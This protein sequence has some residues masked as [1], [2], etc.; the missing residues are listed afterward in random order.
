MTDLHAR[1]APARICADTARVVLI[2]AP[3]PLRSAVAREL[4]A[5]AA[6]LACLERPTHL[7][8]ALPAVAA[9]SETGPGGATVV[10]V[11]VP[12]LPGLASRLRHRYRSQALAADFERAVTA[13]RNHGIARVIVLS[14]AFRYDDDRGLAL[15]PGSPTLTSAEAAPAAAAEEAARLFTRLGV[16]SVVLRLGWTCGREEGIARRVLSAAAR[17]WRLIDADPAAWVPMIAETDAA[18][19]VRP[20]L[21]IPPGTYDLTDGCP[22][23]QG[24]LNARLERACGRALHSLGDPGWGHEG[25]LFGC[26]R[27]ITG[28]AFGALTGW[29]P[30]VTSAADSLAGMLSARPAP[31]EYSRA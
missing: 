14:T 29:R 22:V 24:M 9:D 20:A 1:Q 6:L 13:A 19:A 11:T 30:Q 25:A 12:R 7:P 17:G 16:D 26:S 15:H 10:F 21:T 31:S 8:R 4:S 2:G 28:T 23:T 18:R 3:C 5:A 27:K